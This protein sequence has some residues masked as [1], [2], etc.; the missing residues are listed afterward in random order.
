MTDRRD[1]R[2]SNRPTPGQRPQQAY[3]DPPRRGGN[4]RQGIAEAAAKSFIRSIA[5]SIGRILVRSITGRMR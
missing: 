5:S 2:S 3:D 4:Q 1:D